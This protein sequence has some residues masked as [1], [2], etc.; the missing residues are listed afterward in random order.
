MNRISNFLLIFLFTFFQTFSSESQER[1]IDEICD[2]VITETYTYAFKDGKPLDLDVYFPQSDIQKNRPLIFYVHGGGFSGGKRNEAWISSYCKKLAKRGYVVSSISYRLTRQGEKT[3]FGC[4]CPST[5]KLNT[6]NKAVED[7]QD[8]TFFMIKQRD[9]MGIDPNKIIISGSSAGAETVLMAAYQAPYCYGLDSGPVSYAGVISMAGA[10]VD[11]SKI[12]NESAIPSLLFHGTCD[13][14]VPYASAPHHYC[15]EN[16]P[17]YL[18]L[19]GSFTV[20]E[21]LKKLGKSY[22]LYTYCNSAHEIA[23]SPMNTNFNEIVSFCKEFVLDKK[24]EQRTTVIK[25]E[26]KPCNYRLFSFCD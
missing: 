23:G 19:H 24:N 22:W 1:Y 6:F 7:L 11:T 2:S 20:A 8:A 10:V 26:N 16:K 13:N 9:K 17:G 5:D 12:Y 3:A 21:K 18:F 15:S 14:L 4:D 25:T